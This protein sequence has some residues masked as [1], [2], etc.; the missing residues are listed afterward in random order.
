MISSLHFSIKT[1]VVSVLC[2]LLC[3][4]KD[5]KLKLD[6]T[7]FVH[8]E[9]HHSLQHKLINKMFDELGYSTAKLNEFFIEKLKERAL[10]WSPERRLARTVCAEHVTAVMANHALTHPEHMA[11]F[12]ESFRNLFLWHA[13]EEIEHKSVAFDVY[14]HC[15][16]DNALLL[17]E[18]KRF[19][20]YEFRANVFFASRFL[21]REIGHKVSWKERFGLIKSLYG[22]GGVIRDMR[23]LYNSF[24]KPDFHP[25]DHDDSALVNE[26]REKLAPFFINEKSASH[27][28][29]TSL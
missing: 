25:W 16:N 6:I 24:L 14:K 12:P 19:V 23:S 3:Q 28:R 29:V 4:I 21:L 17:A 5:P 10:E 26:W 9:A 8:Q 22:K 2:G 11:N 1:I 18:Y 15:V 27:E 13:I 20:R 7:N